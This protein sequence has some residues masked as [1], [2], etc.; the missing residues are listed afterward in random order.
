MQYSQHPDDWDNQNYVYPTAEVQLSDVPPPNGG[1]SDALKHKLAVEDLLDMEVLLRYRGIR[2]L[3]ALESLE[4]TERSVLL[5]KSRE[6]FE[7][8]G[9]FPSNLKHTLNRL[10]GDVPQ[11]GMYEGFPHGNPWAPFAPYIHPQWAGYD[12]AGYHALPTAPTGP[13]P[14][15]DPLDDDTYLKRTLGAALLGAREIVGWERYT[16]CLRRL[17][18]SDELVVASCLEAAE[19]LAALGIRK[20]DVRDRERKE[21]LKSAKKAVRDVLLWRCTGNE[22]GLDSREA[23]VRAFEEAVRHTNCCENT[24]SQLTNGYRRIREELAGGPQP[25]VR[26]TEDGGGVGSQ[27][28]EQAVTT[29]SDDQGVV[30]AA[31]GGSPESADGPQTAPPRFDHM[32]PSSS[33][34]VLPHPADAARLPEQQAAVLHQSFLT[35]PPGLETHMIQGEKPTSGGSQA[36]AEGSTKTLPTQLSPLVSISSDPELSHP[37]DAA[38]FQEQQAVLHQSPFPSPP[39]LERHMTQGEKPNK[40]PFRRSPGCN[41]DAGDN[42]Q[43]AQMMEMIKAM[44]HQLHDVKSQIGELKSNCELVSSVQGRAQPEQF[45][46]MQSVNNKSPFLPSSFY[47]NDTDSQ[48]GNPGEDN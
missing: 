9:I 17:K 26:R 39:G 35:G 20:E 42:L 44:T 22:M 4:T 12:G 15:M 21:L 43:M 2:T 24:V 19:A 23:L 37:A 8:L 47:D 10:F 40:I 16:E 36:S 48:D 28:G 7:L 38:V 25:L 32:G 3:R 1:L 46:K 31:S 5:C 34:P 45:G 18:R 11:Q 27:G 14:L 33:D 29:A 30:G 13:E 6:L 41:R